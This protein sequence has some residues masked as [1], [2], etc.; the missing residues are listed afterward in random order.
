[1]G[2]RKDCCGDPPNTVNV[3]AGQNATQVNSK[4]IYSTSVL[5]GYREFRHV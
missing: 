3:S 5:G 1:M 2:D 4:Y